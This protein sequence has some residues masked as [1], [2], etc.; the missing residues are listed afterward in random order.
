MRS[1]ND[2]RAVIQHDM[3][4]DEIERAPILRGSICDPI[5]PFGYVDKRLLLRSNGWEIFK[6]GFLCSVQQL[7]PHHWLATITVRRSSLFGLY[8]PFWPP[9]NECV[10]GYNMRPIAAGLVIRECAHKST[11]IRVNE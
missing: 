6:L 3:V 8:Y 5:V 1:F 11:P 7:L 4:G 10:I 2:S 9:S